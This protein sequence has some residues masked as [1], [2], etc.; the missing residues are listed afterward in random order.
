AERRHEFVDLA[1]EHGP[2]VAV[3]IVEQHGLHEHQDLVDVLLKLW[4]AYV[5]RQVLVQLMGEV[6]LS[7]S[8][9]ESS[10]F[11]ADDR[12]E[13]FVDQ[14]VGDASDRERLRR[15][16]GQAGGVPA[17]QSKDVYVTLE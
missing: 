3:G 4:S 17:L 2:A 14:V 10:Q 8:R 13:S 9:R 16:L 15:I 5:I 12:R 1:E 6:P 7:V 11:I